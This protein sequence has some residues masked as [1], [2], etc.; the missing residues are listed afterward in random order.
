MFGILTKTAEENADELKADE[1]ADFFERT[2]Q[3]GE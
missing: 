3:P 2:V 1:M